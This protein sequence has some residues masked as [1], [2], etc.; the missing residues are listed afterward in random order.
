MP[1]CF[2]HLFFEGNHVFLLEYHKLESRIVSVHITVENTF[3]S[4][5]YSRD[6]SMSNF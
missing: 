3:M 4:N 5:K 1:L 2:L 6:T